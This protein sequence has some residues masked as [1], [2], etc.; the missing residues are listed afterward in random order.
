[1]KLDFN[2]RYTT[3][4]IYA[5][6]VIIAAAA[7][8]VA[9][10][11]IDDVLR[12][13]SRLIALLTPFFW[14]FAIA[15]LLDPLM[16]W[17]ERLLNRIARDKLSR[18]FIRTTA[19][20]L[21]DI[22]IL[23]FLVVMF[24]I[25]LPQIL[26]SAASL[27]SQ[28]PDWF[29]NARNFVLKLAEKYDIQNLPVA[30]IDKATETV[31]EFITKITTL[32]T[33]AIPQ[34]LQATVSFTAG[35]LN[36]VIGMI[37]S[38]YLLANKELFFA[39]LK[40]LG[41]ALFRQ[42]FVD[43]ASALIRK[44]NSIFSGFIIGKLLDS[45]IIGLICLVV[46]S[47]FRWPYPMLISV[48]VGVTNIIPYFGPFIGAIPSIFII[49]LIDPITAFWFALFILLLQQL[50]GNVIGPKILGDS[51]GLSAIWVIFAI[52]VFGSLFGV[53]GM[54]IGVPLFAVIYTLV[55]EF[56]NF[57]LKQRG[58]PVETAAYASAEHP[59]IEK[60]YH[61]RVKWRPKFP[62]QPPKMGG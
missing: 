35:L 12:L 60:K 5:V 37:I 22:F 32:A 13:F 16:R 57:R 14:G 33:S 9:I 25:I 44:S 18:R 28:L 56:A 50:D 59:L 17:F 23:I 21:T 7:V 24:R 4:A 29:D 8:V 11:N 20:I 53:L 34:L 10:V 47:I 58:M 39:H 6:L 54:F 61:S 2:R 31:E 48:I 46:M 43:M 19:I 40:K 30:I 3:I 36:A 42:E 55:R 26:S 62:T 1:M 27:G 49:L 52:T 38:I 15:Y 51:T 41:T 45:L